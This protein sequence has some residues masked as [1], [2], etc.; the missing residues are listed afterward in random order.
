MDCPICE[1]TNVDLERTKYDDNSIIH[2]VGCDDCG[3]RWD[4]WYSITLDY[5][6]ITED[7]REAID[8]PL[9]GSEVQ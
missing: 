4:E 8:D 1:S 3:S 2:K 9:K 5:Y 7:T 6:D